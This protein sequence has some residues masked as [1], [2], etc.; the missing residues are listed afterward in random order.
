MDPITAYGIAG[1]G[2]V[3]GYGLFFA[4]K[5]FL[6]PLAS[7][8][9]STRE[10][11]WLITT[12]VGGSF[13]GARFIGLVGV[14]YIGPYGIGLALGVMTNLVLTL[15]IEFVFHWLPQILELLFFRGSPPPADAASPREQPDSETRPLSHSGLGSPM[16]SD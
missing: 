14:S 1:I 5:R 10:I 11:V 15:V 16:A 2:W 12:L 7:K 4:L 13:L 9:R 6:P 8:E 3:C